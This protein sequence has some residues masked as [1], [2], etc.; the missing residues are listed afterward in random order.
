MHSF[1]KDF[2]GTIASA[3]GMARLCRRCGNWRLGGLILEVK[4][5]S[6]TLSRIDHQCIS[7][8]APCFLPDNFVHL[9]SVGSE[10]DLAD[11]LTQRRKKEKASTEE[12]R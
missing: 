1:A 3:Q 9:M 10:L 11:W 5:A 2:C 7:G 12:F 8:F 4:A 6:I